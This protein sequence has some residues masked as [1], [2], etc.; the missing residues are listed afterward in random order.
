[1]ANAKFSVPAPPN[2]P[3]KS[4]APGT[5]ERD[6]LKKQ[7]SSMA[8]Q[9][10]EI[11]LIIDGKEIKTGDTADSVCPHDHK[12][13]LAKYH[14]AGEKE[15]QM[16]IESSM[17]AHKAWSRMEWHDRIAVFLKAADLLS[18]TEWRY[19]LNAATMLGQSKNVFQ[20]EID[21]AAELA[22][23]FRFNAYYAMKIYEDQPLHSPPGMWNRMEYRPLE[24]FIF[25]VAPFNFTSICGNL[26]TS[27]ALMGNV[28]LLKPASSSVYSAYWIMKL[29]EAAG[30]P[31]GVIN[32]IP[33]S[34][35]IVGKI[36]MDSPDFGGI[37]FT[38]STP[39][40]QSMWKTA[41]NNLSKYKSYPRIVGETG[42]KDF[43]FAHASADLK[44]LGTAL[45]RG[46]FEYQGQKCSAASRAYIPKSIWNSLKEFMIDELKTVRMGDVQDFSNFMNAVIDK[47][48][49]DS[50]TSYIEYAKNS[51]E[52][53]ILFGGN[54]DDSIGYFIEP[55]VVLTT[56]PKF[57]TMEEEIFGPVLTLYVYDDDKYEETLHLCD[58]TSPYSLT[59]AIFAQDRKAIELADQILTNAAGNFY[60]NDKPTGAV[61]GQQPFGGARA[62]G[63]NDKAGSYLNLLRWVSARTIKE[64]FIPPK[65]YRYPFMQ[66]K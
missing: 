11:P 20:A 31:E 9:T 12:T 32:F 16:A 29:L 5:P 37:H 28:A 46:A 40:F 51:N 47:N 36:V 8:R 1:M 27:P 4:Y 58:E 44:A 66:D 22:D 60:I 33:G 23:F 57:K 50:I 17:K 13:V 19:I 21:S 15:I 30:L 48:A 14:K 43:I 61:V 45:I 18:S 63:T 56:N 10:I 6:A 34:G 25:A 3:V 24:G 55:T 26:P 39:T 42:G 52:A 41:A 54:Y 62:S 59:G 7:L 53:E 2:E 38:G 65:D 35:S 49:F 64:N